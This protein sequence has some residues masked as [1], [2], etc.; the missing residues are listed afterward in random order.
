MTPVATL[1]RFGEVAP[2]DPG[3][4]DLITGE[5]QGAAG[6]SAEGYTAIRRRIEAPCLS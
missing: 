3:P 5:D 1:I 2:S 6:P 4:I